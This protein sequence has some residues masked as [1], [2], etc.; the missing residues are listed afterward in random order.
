M[1]SGVAESTAESSLEPVWLAHSARS[2]IAKR[3]HHRLTGCTISV[4]ALDVATKRAAFDLFSQAYEGTDEVRFL[5]DLC[6]KQRII[7][8]RDAQTGELKGF[9]TVH[10]SEFQTT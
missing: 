2:P 1:G 3:T 4:Q 7:L 8:L 10:L 6:E 5:E 9:S